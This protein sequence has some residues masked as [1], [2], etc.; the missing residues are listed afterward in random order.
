MSNDKV[1][2][3]VEKIEPD[4][5]LPSKPT[6]NTDSGFDVVGI[7]VRQIYYH[8]GGNGEQCLKGE[9]LERK[10]VDAGVIELQCNERALIGTGLK[11]T[12][13]P[14][15]E[16]QVRPRSGLALKK[17]LTVLNTPGT[18]DESYRGELG[19][20]IINTSR[21]AQTI[22]LGESIAQIVPAKVLLPEI[23]EKVLDKTHRGDGGFGHSDDKSK[24]TD[25]NRPVFL[26]PESL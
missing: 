18:I 16:I 7:R 15:Y 17:G 26:N 1:T 21:Q 9:H 24:N 23:E 8:G 5:V 25:P 2:L 13:G 19:I 10:F 12:V 14:G 3:Y 11:V 6:T 4:A 20:I 22:T